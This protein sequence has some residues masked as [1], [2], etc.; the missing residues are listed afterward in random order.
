MIEMP[1]M[2]SRTCTK[3]I[4]RLIKQAKQEKDD[5]SEDAPESLD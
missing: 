4:F 5:E 3:S 1:L 2:N